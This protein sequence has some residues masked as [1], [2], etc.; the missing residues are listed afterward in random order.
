MCQTNN[1][2][3]S[4]QLLPERRIPLGRFS[5][6]IAA[7]G[8]WLLLTFLLIPAMTASAT[9]GNPAIATLTQTAADYLA[10]G[11]LD[12][13]ANALE[14]ALRIQPENAE[15]WHFL[16]QVH[17]YRG[18]Y[19][20]AKSMA[21]KS[22]TLSV[23]NTGLKARNAWLIAVGELASQGGERHDAAEREAVEQLRELQQGERLSR[24]EIASLKRELQSERARYEQ[25]LE[26]IARR[27][28]A[29]GTDEVAQLSAELHQV[30]AARRQ[31]EEES[32]RLNEQLLST[33]GELEKANQQRV[34]AHKAQQRVEAVLAQT[35]EGQATLERRLAA[36]V[37]T[38][39]KHN[40]SDVVHRLNEKLEAI[41]RELETSLQE[42]KQAANALS[43]ERRERRA[44]EKALAERGREEALA[45]EDSTAVNLREA[46]AAEHEYSHELEE[47][48]RNYRERLYE[49][50]RELRALR[51]TAARA[52]GELESLRERDDRPL[53]AARTDYRAWRKY[54]LSGRRWGE[55]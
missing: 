49:Q 3:P 32:R 14:R 54:R 44:L 29:E 37:K 43:A 20:G 5:G 23:E 22:S 36:T 18:D 39:S 24:R 35:Q 46:L 6:R 9:A 25:L 16:A 45:E 55:D 28:N 1:K 33:R 7:T 15:L 48:I 4:G 41:S 8:P 47:K 21:E 40:Q 12:R 13:A 26:G 50:G 19:A 10:T 51:R 53:L 31:A 38:A 52:E 30:S 17:H 34:A 11:A 42:R 27:P 2:E